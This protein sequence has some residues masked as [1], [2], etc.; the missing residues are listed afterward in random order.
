MHTITAKNQQ[1]ESSD[2]VP[3]V[4]GIAAVA[5]LRARYYTIEEQ[6][7]ICRVNRFSSDLMELRV[8]QSESTID[9]SLND[10]CVKREGNKP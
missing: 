8:E 6:T 2:V 9:H 5:G 4:A 7:S 10:A 3:V 1:G